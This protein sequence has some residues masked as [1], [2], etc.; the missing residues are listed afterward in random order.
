MTETTEIPGIV[1]AAGSARRMGS[2][3]QVLP[4]GGSTIVATTVTRALDAGLDPVVVVTGAGADAVAAAVRDLDVTVVHNP[5]HET[6]NLSSLGAG[7]AAVPD[8]PAVVLLLADMPGVPEAAVTGLL[9][10][11][12]RSQ[13]WAAICG[14]DDGEGHPLLLSRAALDQAFALGE[15]KPLW[16]MLRLAPAGDVL[17]VEVDGPRPIDVDTVDQYERLVATWPVETEGAN[18]S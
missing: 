6:G 11:W 18:S 14:Y 15:P 1:L 3:K 13:P 4:L 2:P 9:V 12:E 10:A 17:M 7:V 8:A 16:R 5:A